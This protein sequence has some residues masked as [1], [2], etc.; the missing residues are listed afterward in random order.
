L[1]FEECHDIAQRKMRLN[2]EEPRDALAIE[3]S[4]HAADTWLITERHN[5]A[6]HPKKEILLPIRFNDKEV[7]PQEL[8]IEREVGKLSWGIIRFK[9]NR[10][11]VSEY[12]V[13]YCN[14]KRIKIDLLW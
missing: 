5:Q 1:W 3:C 2:A 7:W 11:T 6:R 8:N 4:L 10:R 14:M 9:Y 12:F 13:S